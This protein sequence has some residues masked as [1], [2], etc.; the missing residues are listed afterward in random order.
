MFLYPIRGPPVNMVAD[1]ICVAKHRM[2]WLRGAFRRSLTL[3][4]SLSPSP[5]VPEQL[6]GLLR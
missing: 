6:C 4:S 5:I 2:A 1:G 3:P